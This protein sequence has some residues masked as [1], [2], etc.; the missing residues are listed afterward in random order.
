MDNKVW[1]VSAFALLAYA[2][3]WA[4]RSPL[5]AGRSGPHKHLSHFLHFH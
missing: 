1:T 5:L 4:L 3:R 2:G